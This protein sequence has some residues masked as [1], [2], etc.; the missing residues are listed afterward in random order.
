MGR[1]F[2]RVF[3]WFWLGSSALV[4]VFGLSLANVFPDAVTT[5]RFIGRTAMRALGSEMANAYEREGAAAALAIASAA[6]R[7][8]GF[9]VWLYSLDGHLLAGPPEAPEAHDAVSR[10][11]TEHESERLTAGGATL[12]ARRATSASGGSYIVLW[13]APRAL[14]SSMQP[15]APRCLLRVGALRLGGAVVCL[16]LVCPSVC[17]IETLRRVG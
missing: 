13:D 11:V 7:E 8:G 6:G 2:L 17:P 1:L 5:W 14:R 12:L 9:R 3:L 16:A 15:A 10:A 4:I